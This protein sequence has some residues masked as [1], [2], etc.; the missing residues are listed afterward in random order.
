MNVK[1]AD[2]SA[3]EGS[4]IRV[5]SM[6]TGLA[7]ETLRA[8]ERRYGFPKPE[9]RAGSNRRLYADADVARLVAIARTLEHGYRVGDVVRM[10]LDELRAIGADAPARAEAPDVDAF[11]ERLRADDVVGLEGELRHAAAALGA[12]RFVVE[13]AHPFAVR[14][15]D[16]WEARRIDVRHEHVATECLTTQLRHLLAAYQDV[17]ARPSVLLATL[18]GETHTLALSMVA[19]YL[20]VSGA[21]PRLLGASTPVD[22]LAAAATSLR[23][24]VVGITVTA[25]SDRKTARRHVRALAKRMPRGVPLW[26]GGGAAASLG[27]GEGARIVTSWTAI[28]DA[29]AHWRRDGNGQ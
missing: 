16:A 24:D 7:M 3:S 20:A 17:A 6:R 23:A 18:P 2:P 22:Q 4:T 1:S 19:L 8:W 27:A 15:G 10:P 29:L 5:V 25:A 9:R 14:V 28:D 13:V 12:R 21:K 11:V 26:V